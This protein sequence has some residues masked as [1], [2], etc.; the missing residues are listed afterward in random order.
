MKNYIAPS[1]VALACA[2]TLNA[3]G[4][5]VFLDNF[6]I[7]NTTDLNS[8]RELRQSGSAAPSAYRAVTIGPAEA[9]ANDQFKIE[10]NALSMISAPKKGPASLCLDHDFGNL[11]AR[12]HIG[13]TA[14][15][16]NSWAAIQLSPVQKGNWPDSSAGLSL[17]ILQNGA[18]TAWNNT[19]QPKQVIGNGRVALADKYRVEFDIDE[20]DG[21][22]VTVL[23]NGVKALEN[24]PFSYSA[25]NRYLLLQSN[26]QA[27][28]DELSVGTVDK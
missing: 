10:N 5:P 14:R 20:T 18:W 3:F 28:F 9:I 1:L 22:S 2:F 8:Q 12:Y 16:V 6:N 23:I 13:V 15:A 4:G 26:G 27:E 25:P 24:K 21:K 19:D 7:P 11:G 17:I